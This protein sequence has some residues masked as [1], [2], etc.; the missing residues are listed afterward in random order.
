MNYVSELHPFN[1][2]AQ[3]LTVVR[4]VA[5]GIT[6]DTYQRIVLPQPIRLTREEILVK[7]KSFRQSH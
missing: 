1:I 7:I 3:A 5:L 2:R 6:A 4:Q